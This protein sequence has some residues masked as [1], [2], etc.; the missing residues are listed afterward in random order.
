MLRNGFTD[1]GV[2]YKLA[3]FKPETKLNPD[4][5][6]KYKRT[7]I[8]NKEDRQLLVES[9]KYVDKIIKNPPLIITEQFIKDNNIDII[10]HSFSDIKDIDAQKDFFKIPLDL[11]IFRPLQYNSGISTTDIINKI[12]NS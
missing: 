11:G 7:P 8:Y 1:Y 9:C 3:F 10:C 6:K 2:K 5:A 4:D 12:K